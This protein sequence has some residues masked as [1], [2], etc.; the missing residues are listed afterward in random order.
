M[1]HGASPVAPIGARELA[2]RQREL[3]RAIGDQLQTIRED[4]GVTRAEVARAAGIDRAH[5]SRI[6][7]GETGASLRVLMT[8]GSVLGCDLSVRYFPGSGPRI[9]DRLQAP[10]VEA[11]LRVLDGR[12]AAQPEVPI[13]RPVRGVID[14]VL[15][16]E[17]DIIACEVQSEL[18]RLEEVLR[19]SAEK[20]AALDALE[21]RP[22]PRLLVVRSTTHTREIARRFEATLRAAY[23]ARAV[24]VYEA[25]SQP[26][27]AWPGPAIL[28]ARL[29]RGRAEILER[30]P[31]G[32]RIGC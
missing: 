17:G 4:G 25:L 12:W 10:I 20:A 13:I 16:R 1:T 29:E 26:G 14:L 31:R 18:R 27:N 8:I 28:W 32:V 22:A 30:P 19:R 7:T 6:E 24:D 23:P 9:R 21:Q 2:R 3:K 15:R 5:Y 11:L